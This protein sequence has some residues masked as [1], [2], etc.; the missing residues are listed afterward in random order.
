[1][2]GPSLIQP[3]LWQWLGS[4]SECRLRYSAVVFEQWATVGILGIMCPSS[5]WLTEIHHPNC[6]PQHRQ[7][8]TSQR[9]CPLGFFIQSPIRAFQ[10]F[11]SSFQA[12]K[13]HQ[14]PP[15]PSNTL[16][17][18]YHHLYTMASSSNR[19]DISQTRPRWSERI[20]AE[21]SESSLRL[22][23]MALFTTPPVPPK[24]LYF[25]KCMLHSS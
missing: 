9:T 5:F 10:Y 17:F 13:L 6:S 20:D 24:Q 15:L 18:N 21:T 2:S 16:G 4:T 8:L 23:E 3:K 1:M 25:C 12:H 7:N 19:Q 11:G 22:P 14:S